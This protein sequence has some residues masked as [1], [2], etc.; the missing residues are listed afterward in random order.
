MSGLPAPTVV[1]LLL[2]LHLAQ[3]GFRKGNPAIA[4]IF[5]SP[6]L[7]SSYLCAGAIEVAVGPRGVVST[8]ADVSVRS[9]GRL[10]TE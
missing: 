10:W 6:A 2:F 4:Q 9:R 1:F 3:P 8:T 7:S 5:F